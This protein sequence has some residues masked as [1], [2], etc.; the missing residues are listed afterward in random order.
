M[1]LPLLCLSLYPFIYL[2]G[3]F[4]SHLK[5]WVPDLFFSHLIRFQIC[6]PPSSVPQ[7]PPFLCPLFCSLVPPVSVPTY[8]PFLCPLF[9]FLVP[10]FCNSFCLILEIWGCNLIT[11]SYEI[12][13]YLSIYISTYQSV[14]LSIY[15][16]ICLFIYPSIKYLGFTL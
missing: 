13:S 7:Y 4:D 2:H 8:P 5:L 6:I 16:S 9:C 10:P 11:N 15:L 3:A 1:H 14:C 12:G